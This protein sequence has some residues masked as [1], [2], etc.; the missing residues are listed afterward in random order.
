MKPLS[1]NSESFQSEVLESDVPVLVDFWA[2]WCGPCRAIAPA[3]DQLAADTDGKARVVKVDAD[4]SPDLLERYGVRS[5]PT[6]VVFDGGE[7]KERRI[8]T[9][10]LAEL[11]SVLLN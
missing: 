11:R 8:G 10:G 1:V 2:Q 5:V 6:L 9:G 7:E 3:L 4:E